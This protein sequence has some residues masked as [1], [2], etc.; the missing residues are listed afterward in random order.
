MA[1]TDGVADSVSLPN[2]AGPLFTI[3]NQYRKTPLLSM[4]GGLTGGR[5][6]GTDTFVLGNFLTLDAASADYTVTETASLTAPASD[7]FAPAQVTNFIQLHQ[8]T[9][10][11]SYKKRSMANAISGEA[12]V[13]EGITNMGNM[14][15][16]RDTHLAQI[17]IDAEYSMFH[18]VGTDPA[19]AAT[20]GK[21]R[22]VVTAVNSDGDTEIDAS[23][24]A[25][26]KDLIEQLEVAVL[27]KNTTMSLPVIFAGSRV[28][29]QLNALYGF[30]PES[31]TI[32][33]VTLETIYL[34]NLGPVGVTYDPMITTTTLALLDVSKVA[35]VFLLV[36]EK[37]AVF[38]EP[39][40]K[41]GAGNSEQLYMQFGLDYTH[42]D[43]HGTIINLSVS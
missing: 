18:G 37:P 31:R 3:G 41:T 39:L 15:I 11:F 16:Q 26:S 28:V 9:I 40:A 43:H 17:A 14:Q 25:L 36:P 10:T 38:F 7:I 8:R 2:Y 6:T 19:S 20:N 35:P 34:P 33:G 23:S 13:G 27:A 12:V 21:T 30:A 42:A 29:Q 1:H 22:G 32:G 4:T 5:I 24:A